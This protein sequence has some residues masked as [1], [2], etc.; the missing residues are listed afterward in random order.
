MSANEC[1]QRTR[2]DRKGFIR[3]LFKKIEVCKH[4]FQNIR[5]AAPMWFNFQF[6]KNFIFF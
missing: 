6:K 5:M 4:K 3:N 1:L 2:T